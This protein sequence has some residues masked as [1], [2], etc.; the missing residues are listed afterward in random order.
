MRIQILRNAKYRKTDTFNESRQ[1]KCLPLRVLSISVV[2]FFLSNAYAEDFKKDTIEKKNVKQETIQK[3]IANQEIIKKEVVKKETTKNEVVRKG[4]V[5]VN[6]QSTKKGIVQEFYKDKKVSYY[7]CYVSEGNSGFEKASLHKQPLVARRAY[8]N[9][10]N[11]FMKKASGFKKVII[12]SMTEEEKKNV[13]IKN[14]MLNFTF[15][16]DGRGR[17][18]H[19]FL[20]MKKQVTDQLSAETIQN[21]FKRIKNVRLP[22]PSIKNGRFYFQQTIIIN[23]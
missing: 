9:D 15:F 14:N 13:L 18:V 11:K 12:S 20:S 5:P 21:I 3:K 4:V 19:S 8:K 10:Y 6:K 1:Y 17:M 2:C 22:R 23:S 16:V 7:K